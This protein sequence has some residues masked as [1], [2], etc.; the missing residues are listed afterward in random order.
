MATF[1]YHKL[2]NFWDGWNGEEAGRLQ[3][4]N[5]IYRVIKKRIY[6]IFKVMLIQMI[7]KN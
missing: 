1:R 5:E 4:F 2:P 6:I 3:V 7:S